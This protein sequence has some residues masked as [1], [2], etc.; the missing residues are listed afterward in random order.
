[1]N[2][3]RELI[4]TAIRRFVEQFDSSF[5][6][7]LRLCQFI[8]G[9]SSG[10][11]LFAIVC[12]NI[13]VWKRIKK[14]LSGLITRLERIIGTVDRLLLFTS[15]TD[16]CCLFL[17]QGI[18]EKLL[19]IEGHKWVQVINTRYTHWTLVTREQYL[20]LQETSEKP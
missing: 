13:S 20:R 1:M 6:A 11:I 12:P 16:R 14:R 9:A 3:S 8:Y 4:N 2:L 17:N 10:G 7:I 18:I 19:E 15:T 5:R